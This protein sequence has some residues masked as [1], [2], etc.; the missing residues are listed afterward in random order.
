M[1]HSTQNAPLPFR[2]YSKLAFSR[3]NVRARANR[4]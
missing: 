4:S 3:N 1:L 2:K